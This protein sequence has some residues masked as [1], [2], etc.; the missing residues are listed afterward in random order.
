[1]PRHVVLTARLLARPAL[2][3]ACASLFVSRLSYGLG[4]R[5]GRTQRF[6]LRSKPAPTR[7]AE[8]VQEDVGEAQGQVEFQN[9]GRARTTDSRKLAQ[10]PR[11]GSGKTGEGREEGKKTE[12]PGDRLPFE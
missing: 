5:D 2:V 9:T 11:S 8:E 6:I 12:S 4:S 7:G 10:T 3:L 1:M